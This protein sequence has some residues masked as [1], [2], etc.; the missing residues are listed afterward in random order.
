[1]QHSLTTDLEAFLGEHRDCATDIRGGV[2][3]QPDGPVV[4]WFA[5][6]ACEAK[7]VREA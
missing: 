4:V 2:D 1:M 7:I 5:C 3:D 6:T